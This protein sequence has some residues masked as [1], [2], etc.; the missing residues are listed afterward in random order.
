MAATLFVVA[1]A[2]LLLSAVRRFRTGVLFACAVLT[3]IV[4]VAALHV[5]DP[6]FYG[7][8]V[9]KGSER[10]S[11]EHLLVLGLGTALAVLCYVLL[12]GMILIV[13]TLFRV[14][15]R[16][17]RDAVR[18]AE[19]C[20]SVGGLRQDLS[21]DARRA[22]G[23]AGLSAPSPLNRHWSHTAGAGLGR[24]PISALSALRC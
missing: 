17:G 13:L 1:M 15:D 6:E 22:K 14:P 24:A 10:F 12:T 9:L 16:L 23:K 7:G 4:T 11:G 8:P 5:L 20:N 21:A 3:P 18:S 19:R 2:V